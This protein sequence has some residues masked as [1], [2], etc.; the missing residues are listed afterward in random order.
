MGVEDLRIK[1]DL[2]KLQAGA[3]PDVFFRLEGEF[4]INGKV[5]AVQT[6]NELIQ[7]GD[8][9]LGWGNDTTVTLTL[10][11]VTYREDIYKNKS[12]LLLRITY[13]EQ[14]D[15]GQE[16][17]S[18]MSHSVDYVA[19]L[20]DPTDETMLGENRF[21]TSAAIKDLSEQRTISLLL[22]RPVEED[23]RLATVRGTTLRDITME[24]ALKH[25]YSFERREME[26]RADLI[27]FD[28]DRVRGV[29]VRGSIN[30][31]RH[32]FIIIQAGTSL[33]NMG[34]YLQ[35][36]P[37][38][39]GAGMGCFFKDGIWFMFPVRDFTRF[40]KEARK[41]TVTLLSSVDYGPSERTFSVN[42]K[43]V[44]IIS[45][46]T[47]VGRDL[48]DFQQL[49]KGNEVTFFKSS[50]LMDMMATKSGNKAI[51]LA[52]KT[53]RTVSVEKRPGD[54]QGNFYSNKTFLENIYKET[55]ELSKGLGRILLVPWGNADPRLIVPGMPTEV[56]Y[57]S[58]GELRTARAVVIGM[59]AV[60]KRE[61][62]RMSDR[63][64]RTNCTL[65]LWVEK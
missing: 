61:T 7:E 29:D 64:Y 55:S 40:A 4:I 18:L 43:H 6:I 15:R 53:K 27:G 54:K 25:Y 49:D 59:T 47:K 3:L 32:K 21:E 12:N 34:N 62:E 13:F 24:E 10:P 1:E 51:L 22:S 46:G 2:R 11:V 36:C 17:Q 41:L 8:Y 38:V 48:S 33:Y 35:G 23:M 58:D 5:I 26:N 9:D 57:T 16:S 20:T 50:E 56:L 30:S 31:E 19:Y 45:T 65:T 52:D 37:G 28:F 39:Y 14:N 63:S 44:S 42:N 60:T